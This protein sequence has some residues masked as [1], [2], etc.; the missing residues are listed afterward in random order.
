MPAL[1][2]SNSRNK[3]MVQS[4]L[5]LSDQPL[6]P[7]NKCCN[8]PGIHDPSWQSNVRW[9]FNQW[10]KSRASF[11]LSLLPPAHPAALLFWI[12][13]SSASKLVGGSKFTGCGP[14]LPPG[15]LAASWINLRQGVR[16]LLPPT[17]P[18]SPNAWLLHDNA[19]SYQKNESTNTRFDSLSMG[20]RVE[21][22]F[23][24]RATMFSPGWIIYALS[25]WK[26]SAFFSVWNNT[27]CS[28][29]SVCDLW[30]TVTKRL[31]IGKGIMSPRISYYLLTKEFWITQNTG[32]SLKTQTL[33]EMTHCFDIM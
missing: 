28:A 11:K 8:F 17:A 1:S 7:T 13:H 29:Q 26:N 27:P 20:L 14:L 33:A 22:S 2:S 12:R 32:W 18:H 3:E 5:V 24:R 9:C 15:H 16:L 30:M 21:A 31:V 19:M 23:Q 25:W 10:S 6:E 4:F